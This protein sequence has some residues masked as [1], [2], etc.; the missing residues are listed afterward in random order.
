MKN[1]LALKSMA[2]VIFSK[3]SSMYEA[4]IQTKFVIFL[5]FSLYY[6]Y[7]RW[8]YQYHTFN[9]YHRRCFSCFIFNAGGGDGG[10]QNKNPKRTEA[11][12]LDR[13]YVYIQW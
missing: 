6:I 10:N 3:K 8:E 1:P 11:I 4:S 12:L 13:Q 2:V 7:E 9:S 5:G